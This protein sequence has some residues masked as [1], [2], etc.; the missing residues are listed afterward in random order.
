VNGIDVVEPPDDRACEAWAEERS[1]SGC[2][3]ISRLR[4]PMGRVR[5][6][7]MSGMILV[8]SV[9]C[10]RVRRGLQPGKLFPGPP[11]DSTQGGLR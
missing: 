7:G 5:A 9:L 1:S 10:A 4:R 3:L 6:G 8:T 2:N 11:R